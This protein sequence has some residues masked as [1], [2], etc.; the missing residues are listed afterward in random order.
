MRRIDCD[1]AAPCYGMPRLVNPTAPRARVLISNASSDVA[2]GLAGQLHRAGFEIAAMDSRSLPLGMHSRYLKS[3]HTLHSGSTSDYASQVLQLL[4]RLAPCTF[5]P[6]GSTA[7]RFAAKHLAAFGED[8]ETLVPSPAAFAAADDKQICA[9]ELGSLG[10]AQPRSYSRD[11]AVEVLAASGETKTLVVKPQANMG[12]AQGVRFVQSVA[13]LELALSERPEH[14]GKRAIQEFIPGGP[15]SM[16]AAVLLFSQDSRLSAAFT[17]KKLRHWPASGGA[18]V[19]CES[20]AEAELIDAVLPF[21]EQLHWRGPAEV[22]FK[23]D[24]RDGRHKVIEINPRFP[25]YARF[26]GHCGLDIGTRTVQLAQGMDVPHAPFP[27][28]RVGQR[29]LNPG[30]FLR[31]LSEHWKQAGPRTALTDGIRDA[32]RSAGFVGS[33]LG[34]PLPLLGR[35]IFDW[36][37]LS[38]VKF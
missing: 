18:S 33:L 4:Q 22:E 15:S 9:R 6:I 36:G 23:F 12:A 26:L 38:R 1:R 2:V 19:V 37:R 30:L 27:A 25:G 11:Q 28:Y 16:K 29:Y 7:V 17:M 10:I 14:F 24:E 34:D 32:R 31:S 20:T 8:G 3:H 13:E 21:F 35:T 5:L